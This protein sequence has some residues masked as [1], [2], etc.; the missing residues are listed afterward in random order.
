MI[1][2]AGNEHYLYFPEIFYFYNDLTSINNHKLRHE[3]Q[4]KNEK[5]IKGMK[6]YDPVP[7]LF[8]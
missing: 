4:L 7:S 1:E 8:G 5:I 2:M 3:E 6:Q